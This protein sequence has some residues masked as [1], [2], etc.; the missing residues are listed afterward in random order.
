MFKFAKIKLVIIGPEEP[1]VN[2]L[3]DFQENIELK[4]L[5]Q[6]NMQQNLKVLNH[7]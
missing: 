2:G 3:S 6:I 4:Y 1:L 7:L 5:D